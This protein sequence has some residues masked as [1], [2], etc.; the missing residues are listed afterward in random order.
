MVE[1]AHG[2]AIGESLKAGWALL[3]QA[4]DVANVPSGVVVL[5]EDVDTFWVGTQE[6]LLFTWTSHGLGAAG[7]RAYVSQTVAG[8][9]ETPE[10]ALGVIKQFLRV[11]DANTVMIEKEGLEDR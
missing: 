11:V 3:G 4:D 7:T 1:V 8:D 6:G 2:R 5:V 10:P 9:F